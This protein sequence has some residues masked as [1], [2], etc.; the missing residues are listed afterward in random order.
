M[1]QSTKRLAAE[2]FG[3]VKDGI[4]EEERKS[5]DEDKESE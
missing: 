5:H 4:V 1:K 2:N 3:E